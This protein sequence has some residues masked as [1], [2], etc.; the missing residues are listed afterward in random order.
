MDFVVVAITA[1]RERDEALVDAFL[2]TA[3][4]SARVELQS[5]MAFTMA[6]GLGGPEP[7]VYV[8][9]AGR[10]V[11]VYGEDLEGLSDQVASLVTPDLVEG[12][13]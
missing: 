6:F 8:A 12:K 13:T 5:A 10:V 3:R 7:A 4:L 2:R 11:A 9:D 1:D